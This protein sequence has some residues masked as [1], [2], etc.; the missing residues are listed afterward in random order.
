MTVYSA[1]LGFGQVQLS[2]PRLYFAT[3]RLRTA[4]AIHIFVILSMI[5][6]QFGFAVEAASV[7]A[8]P[9]KE[10]TVNTTEASISPDSAPEPK[11]YQVLVEQTTACPT[12]SNL[13]VVSGE[14]CSLSAGTHT[15][16]S[17]TVQT[18]GTILLEGDSSTNTGVTLN[19][20]SLT[21][22]S[23]GLFSAD[24]L[25]YPGGYYAG[26]GLGGGQG[27]YSTL[28]YARGSGGGYG[29]RGGD[30]SQD[31]TVFPG[32]TTYGDLKAPLDLGSGAGGG[33]AVTTRFNG[34]NGGGAMRLIANISVNI[35]GEISADGSI[36][37]GRI[38]Y[39]VHCGGGGG[40]G[41]SIWIT[42]PSITGSGSITADGGLSQ[43]AGGGG[44]G[45]IL[46]ET[47]SLDTSIQFSY[48]GGTGGHHGE[49]G[50]LYLGDVDPDQSTVEVDPDTVPTNGSSLGTIRVTLKNEQEVPLQV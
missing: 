12:T 19:V 8:S 47:E 21:V 20:D 32:G 44:G 4:K 1:I 39:G 40:S 41:G 14:T 16:D 31:F 43:Y 23:G 2:W 33:L 15:Y 46:V 45:R 22:E 42:A 30:G 36:G 49:P 5:T 10:I 27:P 18:G 7:S 24:G 3:F 6:T 25:G 34:G 50:T 26:E 13:V 28:G 17:I 48:I 11:P 38:Q 9:S 35:D 37:P 29:G